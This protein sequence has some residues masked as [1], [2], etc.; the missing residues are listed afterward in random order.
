MNGK[1]VSL[2][3]NDSCNFYQPP[4][5]HHCS[6][7]ND[8]IEKFDH[9]CPWVGTTIGQ[10]NYR[11]FLLFVVNTT[12]LCMYVFALSVVQVHLHFTAQKVAHDAGTRDKAASVADALRESP[13]ALAC[14]IYTFLGVWFVGGLT[15]RLAAPRRSGARA[16]PSCP[17]AGLPCV[18]GEHEPD[19]VRELSVQLRAR[20]QPVRPRCA[21]QLPGGV[22]RAAAAAQGGLSR[23]RRRG[24]GGG[25]PRR[26]R[27]AG[28][29]AT[30]GGTVL[31]RQRCRERRRRRRQA[32]Q[33]AAERTRHVNRH[34]DDT[35][36]PALAHSVPD[37]KRDRRLAACPAEPRAAP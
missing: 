12:L 33:R 13:A 17:G 28:Q 14:I 27:A 11:T 31:L 22:V 24:G 4:R 32:A 7:N 37:Q 35:T 19:N 18:S 16:E 2:K 34:A 36:R 21:S 15:V 30:A 29:A 10:R 5:A 26:A 23:L 6:V 3:W 20:R 25:R 1:K 8:C 9:H